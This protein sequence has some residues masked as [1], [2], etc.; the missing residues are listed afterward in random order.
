MVAPRSS[1]RQ[2]LAILS[3]PR[4][5]RSLRWRA[6]L[7]GG[8]LRLECPASSSNLRPAGGC[9]WRRCE[10]RP[11]RYSTAMAGRCTPRCHGRIRYRRA[12]LAVHA[13][14][15]GMSGWSLTGARHAQLGESPVQPVDESVRF[16]QISAK[17]RA[18]ATLGG[19]AAQR[20]VHASLF[21]ALKLAGD[22]SDLFVER[23]QQVAG[24]GRPVS[25]TILASSHQTLI[26]A[27]VTQGCD[28]QLNAGLTVGGRGRKLCW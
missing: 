24:L 3:L 21:D 12:G 7:L 19:V 4:N 28:L 20:L 6:D 15:P 9:A 16:V 18:L 11:K 14:Q 23:R 8:R 26:F 10:G 25:P 13:R 5:H 27:R 17:L 2:P 1:L 22:V